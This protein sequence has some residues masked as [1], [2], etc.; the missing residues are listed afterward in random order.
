MILVVLSF[1]GTFIFLIGYP[2]SADE[3]VKI[4]V[5]EGDTLW[6]ISDEYSEYHH[7][8]KDK[9]IKWVERYNG[10]SGERIHSG[11]QL[12]IPVRNSAFEINEIN[13]LASN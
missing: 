5:S 9:F 1:V 10:I 11:D 13:N 8:S 12:L 3:Y 4:T 2:S 7:L 6:N